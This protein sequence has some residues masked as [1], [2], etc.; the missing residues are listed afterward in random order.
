MNNFQTILVAIFL[1]FFVFAVLIFSGILKI[2]GQS[3]SS[4]KPAG[5]VT[6][7]G[8][9]DN[10]PELNKVFEDINGENQDLSIQYIEKSES[11]YQQSLIEAF[12]SG[13]G[14]DLFFVTPDM[15]QRFG[16][17]VNQ[18]PYVSYPKKT[19]SDLYID[20][21]SAYLGKDGVVA[22]PIVV[23]PIVMYYNKDMF[24]NEGIVSPPTYWDELFNLAPKLTKK[25][26]NGTI[27]QSMIALGRYDNITGSK[28][29]LATLMLQSGNPIIEV[30]SEGRYVPVLNANPASLPESP[31]EQILSF[32]IEFSNPSDAVYSWN[33]ALPNSI[34]MFTGGKLAMYVGHAS[35]LFKIESVNPNLSFDVTQVLQ[36]RGTN[37]KRTYGKIY[38]VAINKKSTN[39]PAALGVS[40]IL[41]NGDQAKNFAAAVN[42]PPASRALLAV[43]PTDPYLFTFFNSAIIS[44]TWLDP[45]TNASDN[46][47]AELI[48]NILSNKLSIQDAISKAQGQFESIVKK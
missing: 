7:W 10:S 48:Q 23:D 35:E 17:F 41:S 16:G 36:T 5:K 45:D 3:P 40:G 43:R 25:K 39:L 8:T 26:D 29:I 31:V 37:T 12:A 15:V 22:F 20:G 13:T 30:S 33:K 14:P 38:A 24:S 21:A 18:V 44:R 4:S 1:A 34:D 11:S 32:F 27:L 6:I 28:D 47:F 46:I 2:G 9:F 19:F 42:L